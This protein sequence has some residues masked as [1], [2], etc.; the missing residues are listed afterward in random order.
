MRMAVKLLM[1]EAINKKNE[2]KREY[3]R[4]G[5][6]SWVRWDWEWTPALGLTGTDWFQLVF[7]SSSSVDSFC[8]C[9]LPH[10]SSVRSRSIQLKLNVNGVKNCTVVTGGHHHHF[11]LLFP[12]FLPLF[13]AQP[14]GLVGPSRVKLRGVDQRF[15]PIWPLLVSCTGQYHRDRV[16]RAEK[17]ER[18]KE[19]KWFRLVRSSSRQK[20]SKGKKRKSIDS[21][22][23]PL[24]LLMQTVLEESDRQ[25]TDW[26]MYPLS[27]SFFHLHNLSSQ[28]LSLLPPSALDNKVRRTNLHRCNVEG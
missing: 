10:L 9:Q 19:R 25:R 11:F 3:R 5:G 8:C 14:A 7:S 27:L 28:S 6:N 21:L 16:T 13:S 18:K 20:T 23:A 26:L 15:S 2:R 4:G 17:K 12:S 24:L 1:I 22:H